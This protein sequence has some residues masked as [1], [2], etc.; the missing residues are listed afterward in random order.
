MTKNKYFH[1][2]GDKELNQLLTKDELIAI[3]KVSKGV[4]GEYEQKLAYQTI[5]QK[6]CRVP[7]SAFHENSGIQSFNEGVRYVGQL[8]AVAYIANIDAFKEVNPI[9][10]NINN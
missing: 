5:I 8:L 1:F 3:Q 6:I 7:C 9:K 10:S 2:F 4:A